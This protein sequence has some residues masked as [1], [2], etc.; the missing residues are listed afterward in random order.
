MMKLMSA[1]LPARFAAAITG[2]QWLAAWHGF[3]VKLWRSN[4]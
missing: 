2:L 3:S 4:K 1:G